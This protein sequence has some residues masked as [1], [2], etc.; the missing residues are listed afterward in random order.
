MYLRVKELK[1]LFCFIFIHLPTR[2]WK[3]SNK[4][5]LWF[6]QTSIFDPPHNISICVYFRIQHTYTQHSESCKCHFLLYMWFFLWLFSFPH[7]RMFLYLV[8][9]RADQMYSN[10]S[11]YIKWEPKAAE[12]PRKIGKMDTDKDNVI[13]KLT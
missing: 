3:C 7:S 13:N 10:W 1:S 9:S 12:Q 4:Y 5:F 6:I 2:T 8:M 11:K